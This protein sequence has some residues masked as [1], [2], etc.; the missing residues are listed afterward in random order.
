MCSREGHTSSESDGSKTTSEDIT[1][2]IKTRRRVSNR[3]GQTKI[4]TVKYER[5]N[6]EV[7]C[8]CGKFNRVGILCRHAFVVLKD[9]DAEMIPPKYIVPRWTKNA[10]AQNT[11]STGKDQSATCNKEV[12][13]AKVAAQLW[14]EF[15]NC[16]ALSKGDTSE[17]K[18]MLNFMLE[19][20]G[21]LLKSKGKTQDKSNNSQLL[22]TF[23]GTP[24]S[25]TITVKPPQI[26]KNKGSGKRLKSAREKA[27]EKKKTDGRKCH[28]CDEQPARHDFRNC[29]LNPNKKKKQN[30]KVKA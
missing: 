6:N 29:P 5:A 11:S 9:E 15:Y 14:K 28:Y 22:E 4:F 30:K 8:S 18:E 7:E 1:P 20:K 16:M 12:D 26:S 27:I 24:A 25:T 23:Y 3:E 2:N 13:D 21:K 19:H 17:M 10:W